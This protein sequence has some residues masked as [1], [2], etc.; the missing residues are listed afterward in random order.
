MFQSLPLLIISK[1][2]KVT[3]HLQSIQRNVYPDEHLLLSRM[4]RFLSSRVTMTYS[5]VR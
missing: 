3:K 2:N 5:S 1:D 4:Y